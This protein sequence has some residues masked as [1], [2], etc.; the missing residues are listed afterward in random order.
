[1]ALGARRTSVVPPST[2]CPEGTEMYAPGSKI[3]RHGAGSGSQEVVWR[4]R[5]DRAV[6]LAGTGVVVED[7]AAVGNLAGG[8]A[9]PDE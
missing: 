4:D 1:M 6:D 5:H 7:G 3:D 8:G 2:H 9:R